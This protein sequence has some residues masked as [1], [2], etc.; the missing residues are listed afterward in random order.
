[1]AEQTEQTAPPKP[2][3]AGYRLKFDTDFSVAFPNREVA[4][5]AVAIYMHIRGSLGKEPAPIY[6]VC[7]TSDD[8]RAVRKLYENCLV[9]PDWARFLDAEI[10]AYLA[11][12]DAD[13]EEADDADDRLL[14][15]SL[16]KRAAAASQQLVS[17]LDE[18]GGLAGV[19]SELLEERWTISYDDDET[20]R[21]GCT[22]LQQQINWLV[23]RGEPPLARFDAFFSRDATVLV[24]AANYLTNLRR[25][26]KISNAIR[27]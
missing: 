8:V 13:T 5:R 4:Y 6:G 3:G 15:S 7:W 9:S 2:R 12:A 17:I 21:L 26:L 22:L 19:T 23:V 10:R 25:A 24:N 1:M 20:R 14:G 11:A 18:A 16:Y 27:F